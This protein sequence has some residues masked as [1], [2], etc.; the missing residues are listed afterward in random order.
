MIDLKMMYI[1]L[2]GLFLSLLYYI[3]EII[4]E[5]EYKEKSLIIIAMLALVKA[6][7][8]GILIVLIFYSLQDL[9][10]SFSLFGKE[11]ILGLWANLFI[12]GTI[13]VFGSD[14]FKI[15][16]KKIELYAN[17]EVN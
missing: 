15:I 12:A 13:S 11:V 5:Q 16:K 1:F 2:L 17:K 14:V 10:L 8:G 3:E 4:E 9:K 6:I 7:L